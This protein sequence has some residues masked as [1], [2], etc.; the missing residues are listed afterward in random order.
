M[1]G[2]R[3]T[4]EIETDE[5]R[6]ECCFV[7]RCIPNA[8][9]WC[10]SCCCCA[11]GGVAAS[12]DQLQDCAFGCFPCSSAVTETHLSSPSFDARSWDVLS[13]APTSAE[14]KAVQFQFAEQIDRI[15]MFSH[16]THTFYSFPQTHVQA[17]KQQ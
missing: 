16:R 14:G 10:V 5:I 3:Y 15:N 12:F 7:K 6:A 9:C 13:V 11:E 8:S 17:Q 1:G 4:L 2:L